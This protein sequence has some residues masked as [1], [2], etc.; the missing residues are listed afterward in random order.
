M[1]PALYP[2]KAA[3]CCHAHLCCS[4]SAVCAAAASDSC[5]EQYE[6]RLDTALSA[7]T[8]NFSGQYRIKIV[9]QMRRQIFHQMKQKAE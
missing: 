1:S 4:A 8:G 2:E 3:G 5:T 6:A 9:R 7:R